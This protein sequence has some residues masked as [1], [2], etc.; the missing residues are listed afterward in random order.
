MIKEKPYIAVTGVGDRLGAQAVAAAFA[1]VGPTLCNHVGMVGYLVSDRTLAGEP[2]GNSRYVP[3]DDLADL[4]ALTGKSAVNAIHYYNSERNQL[5]EQ[6]SCLFAKDGIYRAG[7]CRTVQLNMNWPDVTHLQA[8]R[9]TLPDLRIILILSGRSQRH[10]A[11]PQIGQMLRKYH[12]LVDFLLI[13]PSGGRGVT[14]E[15]DYIAPFYATAREAL[16]NTPFVL[17]GGFSAKNV[18]SRLQVLADC[19]ETSDFGTDAETGLRDVSQADRHG[20]FS[21]STATAYI[22]QAAAFFAQG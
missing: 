5:P 15:A 1:D 2:P 4:L 9:Q 16:P 18:T 22:R 11:L 13:D 14:F 7:L 12:S 3:I 8:I 19:L 21:A 20:V 10:V 17:A 6:L